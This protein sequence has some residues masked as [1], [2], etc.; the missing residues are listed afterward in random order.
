MHSVFRIIW[1]T[2]NVSVL[3]ILALLFGAILLSCVGPASAVGYTSYAS[4]YVAQGSTV[5]FTTTYPDYYKDYNAYIMVDIDPIKNWY[6]FMNDLEL[7]PL[8]NCLGQTKF[9]RGSMIC[10]Y[11]ASIQSLNNTNYH[12]PQAGVACVEGTKKQCRY[13]I[14]MWY[15]PGPSNMTTYLSTCNGGWSNNVTLNP[16][17]NTFK[18]EQ[19]NMAYYPDKI[20]GPTITIVNELLKP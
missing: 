20:S 7:Y 18:T 19:N 5:L 16:C 13:S 17:S 6:S 12:I 15:S 10:S 2:V 3:T 8:G 14:W 1:S 4:G 11:L 9:N